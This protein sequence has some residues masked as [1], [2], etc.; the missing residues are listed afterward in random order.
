MLEEVE[1]VLHHQDQVV[2][3]DL[4]VVEQVEL[5]QEEQV[6][7][8]QLIQVEEVEVDQE[9]VVLQEVPADRESLF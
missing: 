5:E 2:Q 4:E 9:I 3:E 8:E 6:V 7:L 1:E